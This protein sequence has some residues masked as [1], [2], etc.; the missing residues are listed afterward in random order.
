M[1]AKVDEWLNFDI[2]TGTFTWRKSP[3]NNVNVGDTAG[4]IGAYGYVIF[5]LCGRR[6]LA[7]RLIWTYLH[8]VIPD[9]HEI[10][11]INGD[12]KDNR[13]TN[14]RLVSRALN[15][16]NR[17]TARRDSKTGFLG[18][19]LHKRSGLYM[20]R[21]KSGGKQNLIGYFKTAQEAHKAYLAKKR[22][23]HVANTI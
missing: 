22:E 19:T 21:I 13:P 17:R 8:G 10:D 6:W 2:E 11:H 12:R 9:G 4:T 23:I 20:A 7:H 18:V 15:N 16:Q 1:K 5:S 3:S 14:L